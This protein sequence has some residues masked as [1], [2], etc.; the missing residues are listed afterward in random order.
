MNQVSLISNNLPTS[1]GKK[2]TSATFKSG[3]LRTLFW[4][5]QDQHESCP[6]SSS[7]FFQEIRKGDHKLSRTGIFPRTLI[8]K[9]VELKL[10]IQLSLET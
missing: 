2:K 10:N 3:S 4:Q 5:K 9:K 8:S 1:S 7:S 6:K